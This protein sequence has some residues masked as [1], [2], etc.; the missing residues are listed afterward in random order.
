[1][2]WVNLAV[3]PR[4]SWP[5]T[6]ISLPFEGKTIVLLPPSDGFACQLSLLASAGTDFDTGGTI[7]S[8]FL[9]RLAW[10]HNSG[11]WEIFLSGSNSPAAPGR[12]GSGTYGRSGFATVDPPHCIYLPSAAQ[13]EA[14]LA[15]ALYREAMSVNSDPFAFLSFYKVLNILHATS[16]QHKKWINENLNTMQ[17]SLA[18]ERLK[19]LRLT[20]ADIG[21]YLH[22]QGRCAVAHAHGPPLV[23]PDTNIDKRR[24]RDDLPLIKALAA[25]FIELKL[26][27]LSDSAFYTR[28]E[29][30]QSVEMLMK[31]PVM[32]DCV[33]Y[34]P[35]T[36]AA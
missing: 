34:V 21:E 17:D 32:D 24:L 20:H 12:L 30:T 31:G 33:T 15:L 22:V 23:N 13:P 11:A 5:N 4:F 27:V 28:F 14:D 3:I 1:M 16:A 2:I 7:L 26:G 35:Y 36:C 25:I 6:K 8:R 19:A 10:S 9:S 29:A 18:L